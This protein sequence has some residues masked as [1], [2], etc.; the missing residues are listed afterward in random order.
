VVSVTEMIILMVKTIS[1][2]KVET[3]TITAKKNPFSIK[4]SSTKIRIKRVDEYEYIL[5]SMLTPFPD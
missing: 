2:S 5:K 4:H 3:T 1:L